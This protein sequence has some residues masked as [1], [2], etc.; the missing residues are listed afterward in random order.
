MAVS[1]LLKV[2]FCYYYT[3][4]VLYLSAYLFIYLSIDKDIDID[5]A[6]AYKVNLVCRSVQGSIPSELANLVNL[7]NFYAASNRLTGT[8]P[9]ELGSLQSLRVMFLYEN[10]LSGPLPDSYGQLSTLEDFIIHANQLTGTI[11]YEIGT[12]LNRMRALFFQDNAFT[13]PL[14]SNFLKNSNVETCDITNNQL[15]GPLPSGLFEAQKLSILA[16][17]INCFSGT[18]PTSMCSMSEAVVMSLDGLAAATSCSGTVKFPLTGI[19]L[20]N[21]LQGTIPSCVWTLPNLTL[22]HAAGVSG[23]VA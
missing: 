17:S 1:L 13:G 5:V 9:P 10:S 2:L 23:W 19:K 7:G 21:T 6:C 11:P 14:D 15:T 18:L 12:N 16:L 4:Y 20:F 22:F 3:L 8:L